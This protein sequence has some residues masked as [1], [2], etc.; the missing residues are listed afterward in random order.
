MNEVQVTNGSI[1]Q[2][3]KRG[4]A[5]TLKDAS[6]QE[7]SVV[8][9]NSTSPGAG[10]NEN[11]CAQDEE[12]ALAP[13]PTRGDTEEACDTN[14]EQEVAGEEGDPCEIEAEEDGECEGV[15]GEDGTETCRKDG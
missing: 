15:G 5:D 9:A 1:D 10:S 11:T 13:N 2:G 4:T 8:L 6:H 12:V 14:A 3:L 7:A